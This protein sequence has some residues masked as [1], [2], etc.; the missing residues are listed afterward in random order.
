V[1]RLWR[2]LRSWWQRIPYPDW[3]D[4][5]PA[6]WDGPTIVGESGP[7]PLAIT[8]EWVFATPTTNGCTHPKEWVG[9]M[10]GQMGSHGAPW[11]YCYLCGEEVTKDRAF[12]WRAPGTSIRIRGAERFMVSPGDGHVIWSQREPDEIHWRA[13]A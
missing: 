5:A 10:A 3:E 7:E 12:T 9:S 6:P 1:R 13:A 11:W 2:R 4:Q 8:N